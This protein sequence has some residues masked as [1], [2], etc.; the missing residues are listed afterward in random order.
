[1]CGHCVVAVYHNIIFFQ[2]HWLDEK[3][4][5]TLVIPINHRGFLWVS[6]VDFP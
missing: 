6:N 3:I 5:E 2:S 4:Y 1:M